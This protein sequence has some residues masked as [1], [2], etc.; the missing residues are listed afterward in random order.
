MNKCK[1]LR[2]NRQ[3]MPVQ[4]ISVNFT[5]TFRL[6]REL[7]TKFN[8]KAPTLSTSIRPAHQQLIQ[9][10]TKFLAAWL[11]D[12]ED[13]ESLDFSKPFM[14]RT[15]NV[16]LSNRMHCSPR[17]IQN[18]IKRLTSCGFILS[19]KFRGTNAS[20]ELSLNPSWMLISGVDNSFSTFK[21]NK[22]EDLENEED[23]EG[24]RK[25]FP[26][27]ERLE[28]K[29]N[30][31]NYNNTVEYC[32]KNR[33]NK[34]GHDKGIQPST[35]YFQRV[36]KLRSATE[37]SSKNDK[38]FYAQILWRQAKSSLYENQHFSSFDEKRFIDLI[39]L[40]YENLQDV[41]LS[42]RHRELSR[43]I[44]LASDYASMKSLT[45]GKTFKFYYPTT[46]FDPNCDF[47]FS[48]TADWFRKEQ[49]YNKIKDNKNE[50]K[51]LRFQKRSVLEKSITHY[52]KVLNGDLPQYS[53]MDTF[54][55]AKRR[56]EQFNDES[57]N[58]EF[59]KRVAFA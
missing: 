28:L 50:E 15:N 37:F 41:H 11:L 49:I 2:V 30:L 54:R 26:F 20:Y 3:T 12:L 14:I 24:I 17:S 44:Q 59:L 33:N 8:S 58:T 55:K 53:L 10:L 36:K 45:S 48:K 5:E 25:T 18:Y 40:F 29:R 39:K 34:T 38:D 23:A 7:I 47:G 42:F 19:K 22:N 4:K 16:A 35:K 43:R 31:N 51:M 57:L 9:V 56:V 21:S 52:L 46:Y 32:G 6:Q 13:A 1:H 27:N